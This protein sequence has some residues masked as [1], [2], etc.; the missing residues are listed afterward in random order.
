MTGGNYLHVHKWRPNFRADKEETHT[1]PMWVRFHVL[2]VK[3]YI[4]RWLKQAGNHIGRTIKVD[5]AT[6]LAS[7]GKFAAFAS[8]LIWINP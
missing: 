3:C 4:V 5:F 1:M 7:R 2:S 6:L 8:R